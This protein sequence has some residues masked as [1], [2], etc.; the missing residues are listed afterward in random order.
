MKDQRNERT[1]FLR[2]GPLEFNAIMLDKPTKT[3]VLTWHGET[4]VANI[5]LMR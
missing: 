3:V 2:C 1:L 5:S 4:E